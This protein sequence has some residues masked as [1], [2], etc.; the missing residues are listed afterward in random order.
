MAAATPAPAAQPC[1]PCR[2]SPLT[3]TAPVGRPNGVAHMNFLLLQLCLLL[4]AC[5]S[6][7]AAWWVRYEPWTAS[8]LRWKWPKAETAVSKMRATGR[9]PGGGDWGSSAFLH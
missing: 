3:H 6:H 5:L 9:Q 7:G 4:C 1:P 8:C 2:R